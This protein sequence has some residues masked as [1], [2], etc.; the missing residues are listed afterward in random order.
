MSEVA[1]GPC[2]LLVEDEALIAIVAAD[3]LRELGF[4]VIEAGTARAA[5]EVANAGM[6]KLD[7]AI[8]DLGLPDR[9]GDE[10]IAELRA[11]RA[12]IPII[13]ATGYGSDALKGRLKNTDRI[14][15]VSKP[16]DTANLRDAL[17]AL[18][19]S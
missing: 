1:S 14:I 6:D 13:V 18:N 5:M 7:V 10:L 17:A 19:V 3:S 4:H 9:R 8:V 15:V 16:Y 2:A 12:D 11:L